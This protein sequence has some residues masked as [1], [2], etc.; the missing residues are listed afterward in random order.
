ML[1]LFSSMGGGSVQNALA[2]RVNRISDE[3]YNMT[4]VFSDLNSWY[5]ML[6][7]RMCCCIR[8]NWYFV[9]EQ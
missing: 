3:L 8:K 5:Q 2:L 7:V 1:K 9:Q 4:A 6:K